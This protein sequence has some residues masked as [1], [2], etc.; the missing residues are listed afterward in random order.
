MAKTAARTK[1]AAALRTYALAFPE[2]HED[3]PW[4]ESAIKVRGKTFLFLR[5]DDSGLSLS[6]KL[7]ESNHSAL[8]L[9]FAEP[10]GYGLAK[11]GWVTA[12][13]APDDDVPLPILRDW[14]DESYRAIAPKKL[15]ASPADAR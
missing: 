7:P 11:S 8:M 10:T 1:V 13:F 5:A 9:P 14:I 12:R 3:T 6:T 15:S 2:A 4:G